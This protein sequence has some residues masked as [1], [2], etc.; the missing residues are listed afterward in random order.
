MTTF[1]IETFDHELAREIWT[2]Q[3]EG[4]RIEEEMRKAAGSPS[5]IIVYVELVAALLTF[6]AALFELIKSKRKSTQKK[7]KTVIHTKKGQVDLRKLIASYE[8]SIHIE[9]EEED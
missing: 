5:E 2:L 1:N 3:T 6:A 8:E 7:T 9:V 4:I